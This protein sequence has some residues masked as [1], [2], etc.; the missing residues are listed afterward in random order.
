CQ[1]GEPHWHS[2]LAG[3]LGGKPHVFVS[4]L[5]G[6]TWR[7]VL[8]WQKPVVKAVKRA[9]AP[10]SA[11]AHCFPQGERFDPG[12]DPHREDLRKNHLDAV[13]GTVVHELGHRSGADWANVACCVTEGVEH[14][15]VGIEQCLLAAHPN[16][17]PTRLGTLGSATH[18]SV[19][20]VEASVFAHLVDGAD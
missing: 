20:Q 3:Q 13:A 5:Q 18:R 6:K 1:I 12:L 7:V 17:E 16:G 11:G 10:A 15:L 4:K 8:A 19:K 2:E 14:W 9:L